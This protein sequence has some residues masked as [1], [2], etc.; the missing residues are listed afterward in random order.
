MLWMT[1]DL[2][3]DHENI[4][5]YC[6]RPWAN[7]EE[8]GDTLIA[9]INRL[10][11][12]SDDLIVAGDFAWNPKEFKRRAEQI[13]C[14]HVVFLKGNHDYKQKQLQYMVMKRYNHQKLLICHYPLA[15]IPPGF[16][17][18]HGHSHGM[19]IPW[20]NRIDVGVDIWNYMPVSFDQLMEYS[21]QLC[22]TLGN[23][24][25]PERN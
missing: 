20:A 22:K 13:E 6:K 11:A 18:V 15:T 5:E 1:A 12:P 4:I 19:L 21:M 24:L 14:R 3:C 8:M 9:N 23:H 2:H 16:I 7:A 17:N 25:Q 10:V